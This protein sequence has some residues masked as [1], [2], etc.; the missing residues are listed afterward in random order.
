MATSIKNE[1]DQLISTISLEIMKEKPLKTFH[2][3]VDELKSMGEESHE[4]IK[5]VRIGMNEMQK[6]TRNNNKKII[7]ELDKSNR[8]FQDTISNINNEVIILKK[9]N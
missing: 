4:Q 3:A 6:I 9:K 5:D 1:F 2:S 8:K 7:S